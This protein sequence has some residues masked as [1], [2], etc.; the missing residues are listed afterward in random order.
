MCAEYAVEERREECQRK[1]HD[2]HIHRKA[3]RIHEEYIDHS[4]DVNCV[5]NDYTVDKAQDSQRQQCCQHHA[6]ERNL[7]VAAEVVDKHQC[8][9]SQQ[10]EDVNT[11]REAHQVGDKYNPAV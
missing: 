2:T 11:Y 4:T 10:V 6:L 9:N 8:W 1:Y 7:L 5:R 3:Q